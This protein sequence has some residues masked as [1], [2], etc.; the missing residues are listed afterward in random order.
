MYNQ[1]YSNNQFEDDAQ[2]QVEK[3]KRKNQKKKQ[4]RKQKKGETKF[5]IIPNH[6]PQFNID[7]DQGSRAYMEDSY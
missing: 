5:D 7:T 3:K 4:K 1:I 6:I 2:L